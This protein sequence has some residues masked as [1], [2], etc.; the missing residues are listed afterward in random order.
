MPYNKV[1]ERI[2]ILPSHAQNIW[3]SSFNSAY[4]QYNGDE[5]KA[6]A[7]AWSAVKKAG[8]RKNDKGK[9]IKASESFHY[10]CKL[11]ENEDLPNT[12]E[13]MRQG[14]WN[15]P[16]YGLFEITDN[17]MTNIISNFDNKVR[18]VDISFDLEH[19]ET[20]HKSEAVCWVKKLL[21]K[22]TSLLA[23]VDWTEFGK[24]KIKTKA[25]KY[26][27][28]EFK[29]N[30]EDPETGKQYNNVL[31]GGGLTNRPFIK[32][33]S[34]IMLSETVNINDLDSELYSPC[35]LNEGEE[36]NFMNKK[37]LGYLKLSETSTEEEINKAVNKLVEDSTKLAETLSLNESLNNDIK[38]LTEE[39]EIL[40][41]Q[42]NTLNDSKT[43]VEK[44]N[45]K[46]NE[47]ITE[48]EKSLKETEWENAYNVALSEKKMTPA[49]AET[50]KS[51]FMA[52]P[53]VTKKLMSCLQPIVTLSEG[54][55]G[56]S[57]NNEEVSHLQ[58]FDVEVKKIMAE[59]SMK[60]D[61][62]LLQARASKPD[63]FKLADAER[64][65]VN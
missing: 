57:Q 1:P 56:S 18:G 15:H 65:G 7:T 22:G 55:Q 52:N 21:K 2:K 34:P 60:Y 16:V 54:E 44:A 13:I 62:A 39:K 58:L 4:K 10:I 43:D 24:E 41:K 50:F 20:S 63:L 45:I 38:K 33:M 5:E 12:I 27:S 11:N 59:K 35:K 25:F 61:E 53:E 6:N 30:Y 17:T 36:G 46:L 9:W 37:L 28:P 42:V 3:V 48:I 51:Q 8:Y 64:K 19:G 29:F 31:F 14:K 32:R 49:M 47:R 40:A 23:E 26:F